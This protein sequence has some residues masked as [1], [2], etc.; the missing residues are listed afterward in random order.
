MTYPAIISNKNLQ[1]T[2][3]CSIIRNPALEIKHT[4]VMDRESTDNIY[5][6]MHIDRHTYMCVCLVNPFLLL[7]PFHK[8]SLIC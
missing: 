2:V 8:K 1:S 3:P 4:H 5:K 7:S 6:Y